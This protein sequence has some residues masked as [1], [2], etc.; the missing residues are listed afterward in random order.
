LFESEFVKSNV[1]EADI[2]PLIDAK[3]AV[4]SDV[5]DQYVD[6]LKHT[7]SFVETTYRLEKSGAFAGKGTPQGKALVDE[8]LAAAATELRNLIYTAWIRS[9]DPIPVRH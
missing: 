7:H 1:S 3:P 5:F 9:A 4:I 6:Y 8:R 2:T